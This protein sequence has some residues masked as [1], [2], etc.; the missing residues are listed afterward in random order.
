[1]EERFVTVQVT[2]QPTCAFS[3]TSNY[4]GLKDYFRLLACFPV[5]LLYLRAGR[6]SAVSSAGQK[7]MQVSL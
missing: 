7:R 1:M 6:K 2:H 3:V 4:P 5:T